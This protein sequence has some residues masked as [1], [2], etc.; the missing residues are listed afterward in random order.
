[1]NCVKK[2]MKITYVKLHI[3]HTLKD[4]PCFDEKS[5]LREGGANL[6]ISV[7]LGYFLMNL[8]GNYLLKNC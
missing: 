2:S 5:H 4:H 6:R 3:Y 7:S 1:M 8:E